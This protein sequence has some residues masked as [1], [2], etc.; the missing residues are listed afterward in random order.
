MMCSS[1]PLPEWSPQYP[2]AF[3]KRYSSS[4]RS[5]EV[6][7]S[8]LK[9]KIVNCLKFHMMMAGNSQVRLHSLQRLCGI[10]VSWA[11][12]L[13]HMNMT[14]S[15]AKGAQ[16]RCDCQE[17]SELMPLWSWRFDC[18][19]PHPTPGNPLE[20]EEG[21]MCSPSAFLVLSPRVSTKSTEAML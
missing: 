9:F 20:R 15:T 4:S 14:W 5:L 3:K 6:E 7:G 13:K 2:H 21:H 18:F 1:S 12:A 17:T 16:S 11:L 19:T 8:A 10:Y